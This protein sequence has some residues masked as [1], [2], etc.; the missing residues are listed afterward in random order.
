MKLEN[1]LRKYNVFN[2]ATAS[3][4]GDR[5]VINL[6]GYGSRDASAA[7]FKFLKYVLDCK[8]QTGASYSSRG[9]DG[10]STRSI[11]TRRQ[12]RV[13]FEALDVYH[14]SRGN[15]SS[16]SHS[17]ISMPNPMLDFTVQERGNVC[18]VH[19]CTKFEKEIV[20]SSMISHYDYLMNILKMYGESRAQ[21][22]NKIEQLDEFQ[23]PR[24]ETDEDG[25]KPPFGGRTVELKRLVLQPRLQPLGE[26]APDLNILERFKFGK[27]DQ[28]PGY[29]YDFGMM[30]VAKALEMVT[31]PLL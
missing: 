9:S 19:F 7:Q 1:L 23:I 24:V 4:S 28:I 31:K 20:I 5:L 18:V 3:L 27:K 16:H 26:L 22:K 6:H 8:E 10:H 30:P 14:S 13:N 17:V 21:V 15:N 11:L 29:L 12:L 25:G 2:N